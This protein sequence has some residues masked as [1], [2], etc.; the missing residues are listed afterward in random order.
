VA[1]LGALELRTAKHNGAAGGKREGPVVSSWA[2]ALARSLNFTDRLYLVLLVVLSLGLALRTKRV[3]NCSSWLIADLALLLMITVLANQT[4]CGPR[5]RFLHDW[6]P[7][8]M[9]IVL[10][11]QVAQLSFIFRNGWQDHYLLAV[12]TRVFSVPPTVWL[13][14]FTSPILSEA[15]NAGYFSYF[16][17]LIIVGGAFYARGNRRGFRQVMD[18]SVIA[19]MICYGFFLAFPTEGPAYTLAAEHAAPLRGEGPFWWMVVLIQKYAGVHGNA[20]PSSHVAAGAVAVIFAWQYTPR[21]AAALTPLVFLLCA[22]AVYDRYHYVTDVV[23]GMAVAVV[24]V[25]IVKKKEVQQGSLA[26]PD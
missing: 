24:A 18:A 14:H 10:F 1:R 12:E 21:L 6:Y 4:N 5:R 15:F 2:A 16:V 8:A 17:L 11:E 7:V 13:G 20:F 9:F 23:G 22:G 19:Y 25:W 26:C 3:A